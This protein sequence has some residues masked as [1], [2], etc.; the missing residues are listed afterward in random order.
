MCRLNICIFFVIVCT[1]NVNSM[2]LKG[3][4][5]TRYDPCGLGVIHF[6]RIK[7]QYWGGVI[8]FGLYSNLVEVETKLYFERPVED[9]NNTVDAKRTSW[10]NLI[11]KHVAPIPHEYIFQVQVL[12]GND[13]DVPVYNNH[14]AHVCGRRSLHRTELVSVRT[15]AKAGDWP[16]HVAMLI[17]DPTT[18]VPKYDCGGSIISRTTVLT[19]GHCIYKN[20]KLL[21]PERV[22]VIAGTNKY[23]DL[24]QAGRQV[25]LF[26]QPICL[27]GPAYDKNVLFEKEAMMVG[28]GSTEDN[29][30]SEVLR[31]SYLKIQNDS[32]CIAFKPHVYKKLMNDSQYNNH[33]A[34]V[35]GRRSLHRT[36]LVSVR[37]EAKAGDWPWHVAMLIS[38]PT[39]KV[40][41][42]DCG[43]SIISRTT[44]LTDLG[45][46]K[47]NSFMYTEFVQPI[48]LWGPAYDKNVLFEKEAMR[49]ILATETAVEDLS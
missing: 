20:D 42:Y 15:E 45:I 23:K 22:T 11:V 31:S 24:Y 19:A 7:D 32:T 4:V 34:H 12:D 44:V 9:K 48:C 18:K 27:W 13:T 47:V 38:D 41:K 43:G 36:E 49:S 28:F 21:E 26:V 39:T 6:D 1:V 40:P 5:L 35:C 3:P 10:S 29:K 14:Y 37:T 33:Y 2:A 17:S 8:N 25:L 30:Q 16:W 46:I